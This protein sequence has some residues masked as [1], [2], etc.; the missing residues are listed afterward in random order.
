MACLVRGGPL[1]LTELSRQLGMSDSA[2][3]IS[4]NCQSH[5][6]GA[7]WPS[8]RRDVAIIDAIEARA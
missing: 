5:P 3:R 1:T 2:H 6:A 8:S 4:Y 7:T